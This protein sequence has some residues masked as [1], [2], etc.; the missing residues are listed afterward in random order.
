M[1]LHFTGFFNPFEIS[2]FHYIKFQVGLVTELILK[3][4]CSLKIESR[5]GKNDTKKDGESNS[6]IPTLSLSEVWECYVIV[7]QLSPIKIYERIFTVTM[8]TL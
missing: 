7:V 5:V 6:F 2:G 4:F 3:F 8:R 1:R